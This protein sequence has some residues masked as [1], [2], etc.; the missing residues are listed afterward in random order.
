MTRDEAFLDYW[1][2]TSAQL[3]AAFEEW[4]PRFFGGHPGSQAAAVHKALDNGKRLRGCL[5]CLVSD[6]LGGRREDALP[7]AVAVECVQAASLIHDDFVDGD[8]RRRG[9]PAAWT[10]YGPRKAVLLGDLIF[11]TVLA[12]MVETGRADGLALAEVIAMMAGG[13]WHEPLESAEL[14]PARLADGDRG[15]GLYPKVIYLKTGALFGTAARLGAI[16]AASTPDMADLAFDAGAHLGEAYQIADDLRDLVGIDGGEH[17]ASEPTLL[18]PAIAHFCGPETL[19]RTACRTVAGKPRAAALTELMPLLRERMHQAVS[20]RIA[21][22][23]DSV[24]EFP[25]NTYTGLL[26]AAPSQIVRMMLHGD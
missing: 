7:R 2:A 20:A 15:S 24:D 3:D 19:V 4:I 8:T 1:H 13:A 23:V 6:A 18:S 14:D 9:R 12:R 16:S 25:N 26:R 10:S 21:R 11:A 17:G 22:A 5:L